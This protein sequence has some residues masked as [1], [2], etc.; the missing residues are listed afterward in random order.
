MSIAMDKAKISGITG[1]FGAIAAVVA[2]YASWFLFFGIGTFVFTLMIQYG[3]IKIK[4][5]LTMAGLIG[6]MS[7][8]WIENLSIPSLP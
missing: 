7:V 1:A 8:Y 5:A 4:I 2:G 6:M 3:T